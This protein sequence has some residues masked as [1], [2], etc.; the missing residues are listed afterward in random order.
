[1]YICGSV[2]KIMLGFLRLVHVNVQICLLIVFFKL[3]LNEGSE[4]LLCPWLYSTMNSRQI[5]NF[6]MLDQ[7]C[8]VCKHLLK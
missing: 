7:F 5:K 6:N 2:F 4:H 8:Q 3:V 1:M